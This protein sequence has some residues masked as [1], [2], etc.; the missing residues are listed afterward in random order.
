[1]APTKHNISIL[2]RLFFFTC[3]V[4]ATWQVNTQAQCNEDENP[5]G[6]TW[7]FDETKS[8]GF[9]LGKFISDA[10]TPQI[11]IDSK[12]IRDYIRDEKFQALRMRCGEMRTVDAIYMKS[13]RIA[14]YNIARA[15][16]IS[17]MAVLEHRNV[18][19][20]IP[21]IKS[22]KVPLT[23]EED[24]IFFARIKHLPARLYKDSPANQAGDRD[25]LQ[26]F[27]ASAYLTYASEAPQ[28]TKT[29]G[30]FV[31]WGEA[32]F[33]VGGSDDQRDKRANKQG[34]RFGRDLLIVKT[35]LPSDYL[36]FRLEDSK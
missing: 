36:T 14:E 33:V 17:L 15:L 12:Y 5:D 20:E 25:K 10:F 34:E 26:H 4:L 32:K 28:L 19:F 9:S 23:F 3:I 29:A 7:N 30:D 22:L 13:L 1:M 6:L 24:S 35:L 31:E 27:F 21:I 18:D 11:I 8:P 16:F 2:A